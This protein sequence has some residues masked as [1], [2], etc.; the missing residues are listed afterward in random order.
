MSKLKL[1]LVMLIRLFV[2]HLVVLFRNRARHVVYN[3]ELENDIFNY[4]LLL[5]E[6]KA[7]HGDVKMLPK[8]KYYLEYEI[9][10]KWKYLIYKWLVWIYLDDRCTLDTFYISDL[11]NAKHDIKH[12]CSDVEVGS[13]SAMGDVR[14]QHN[15]RNFRLEWSV[16]SDYKRL[17]YY[18]MKSFTTEKSPDTK[19]VGT[20][21]YKHKKTDVY[22][23]KI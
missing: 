7:I 20:V 19:F 11:S 3:Y 13:S 17:N 9:I 1:E 8:G 21:I 5:N 10:P 15:C 2:Y 4:Y 12:I 23:K 16:V 18:Y 14:A 6:L 22:T